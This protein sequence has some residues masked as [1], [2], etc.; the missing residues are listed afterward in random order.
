MD[1]GSQIAGDEYGR[2]S[3]QINNAQQEFIQPAVSMKICDRD[4]VHWREEEYLAW[5]GQATCESEVEPIRDGRNGVA[6]RYK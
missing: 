1:G 2:N 5:R 4:G 3:P 6:R